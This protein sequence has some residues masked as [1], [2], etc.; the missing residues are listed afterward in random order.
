MMINVISIRCLVTTLYV[1]VGKV[2]F[3]QRKFRRK[4]IKGPI[5][6][7]LTLVN[8]LSSISAN[9]TAKSDSNM[10]SCSRSTCTST[11]TAETQSSSNSLCAPVN[12]KPNIFAKLG[13]ETRMTL[14]F[15]LITFVF[16]ICYLSQAIM[17]IHESLSEHLWIELDH[18]EFAWYRFL[19]T[20]VYVNS[21]VNP[22]IYGCL[23]RGFR[24]EASS[25]LIC[26]FESLRDLID[27]I[28]TMSPFVNASPRFT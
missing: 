13:S 10:G 24:Q 19:Y 15:M 2:V 9:R 16:V 12:S 8:E 7:D 17:L 1:L 6:I 14:T 20:L 27:T 25:F 22:I 18:T 23:D 3:K 4:Y 5:A 28:K 11:D 26:L 21:I